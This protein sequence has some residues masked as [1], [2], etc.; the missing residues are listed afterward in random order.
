MRIRLTKFAIILI[1]VSLNFLLLFIGWKIFFE[2]EESTGKKISSL[3]NPTLDLKRN[4]K[5]K[6]RIE[7]ANKFLRKSLTIVFRD[8]YDFDNDLKSG[9][10]HLVNLIP[11]LKILIIS[12]NF[13]YPPMN[14]LTSFN[15]STHGLSLIFKENV[16]FITLNYDISKPSF[17]RNPLN[18]L[19]TKFTLFMPDSFR[20][21]NGRQFFQRILKSLEYREILVIPFSSNNRFI[22]YCFRLNSDYKNWTLEYNV[23]NSTRNCNYFT[24]KNAILLETSI[25]KEF[26]EPFASPF[27]EYFYLQAAFENFKVN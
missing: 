18:F 15:Q 16:K 27:P 21:S 17:E 2:S 14:I 11:N 23:R 7:E 24:Q 3:F 25:L 12:E 22:N 26:H 9:I 10:E 4:E 20:L 19:S 1:I 13:P 6:D 5:P 8:F